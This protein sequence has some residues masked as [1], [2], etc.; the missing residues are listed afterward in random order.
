MNLAFSDRWQFSVKL[1][2][3]RISII[4]LPNERTHGHE[5]T[6]RTSPLIRFDADRKVDRFNEGLRAYRGKKRSEW[7]NQPQSAV[8]SYSVEE[9]HEPS[10]TSSDLPDVFAKRSRS[11]PRDRDSINIR[12]RGP[13]AW[14]NYQIQPGPIG[15]ASLSVR[16][17]SNQN[18]MSV[19]RERERETEKRN[20]TSSLRNRHRVI[21]DPL[22]QHWF[23][24]ARIR[25]PLVLGSYILEFI[26]AHADHQDGISFVSFFNEFKTRTRR[27]GFN[28][29]FFIADTFRVPRPNRVNA[30]KI[31]A[32]CKHASRR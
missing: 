23:A 15:I 27:L 12:R 5:E 30:V 24:G 31:F 22:V 25:M 29:R 9:R 7:L 6:I 32:G 19:E 1:A 4:N 2:R 20:D 10:R 14:F 3:D 11:N 17:V 13:G 18:V 21:I 26:L 28:T 16:H 8:R